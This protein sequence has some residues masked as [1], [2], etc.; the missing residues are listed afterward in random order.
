MT[1]A[2]PDPDDWRLLKGQQEYLNGVALTWRRY[3]ALRTNWEHEHCDFCW[4]KFLDTNY[5]DG[6]A[7]TLANEPENN[8]GAGYTTIGGDGVDAGEFRICEP[9][10]EDFAE[11][12]GWSVVMS[13]PESWPYQCEAQSAADR[14]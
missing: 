7:Q 1:S 11:R 5:A 2:P 12:F 6:H 9:C 10:F 14:R 3:Q 4:T 13:D 8:H